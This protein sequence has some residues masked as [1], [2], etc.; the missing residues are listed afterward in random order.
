MVENGL[1]QVTRHKIYRDHTAIDELH[2]FQF[3]FVE[4]GVIELAIPEPE[5]KN[6][7]VGHGKIDIGKVASGK[8]HITQRNIIDFGIGKI[9]S[10]EIA[11][12]KGHGLEKTTPE[13]AIG[14]R[15]VFVVLEFDG[16]FIKNNIIEVLVVE[17][18]GMHFRYFKQ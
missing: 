7:L 8:K 10:E 16:F 1:G 6:Y 13:I 17:V 5:I 11:V 14:K 2:F 4:F 18:V 12:D 3:Q 15:T 9:A